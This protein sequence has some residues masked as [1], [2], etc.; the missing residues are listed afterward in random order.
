L[1]PFVFV[2]GGRTITFEGEGGGEGEG[3]GVLLLL[4]AITDVLNGLERG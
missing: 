2:R 4:V 3:A 1:I